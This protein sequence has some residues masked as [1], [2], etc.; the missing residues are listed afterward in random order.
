L[1]VAGC[2][3]P[4][5]DPGSPPPM[6]PSRSPGEYAPFRASGTAVIE[7]RVAGSDADSVVAGRVVVLDPNTPYAQRWYAEVG[8][9][10][11]RFDELPADTGFKSLR[12]ST[13][14]DSAGKFRFA[15][16]APGTYIIAI[17]IS[18]QTPTGRYQ[19]GA[20]TG[21]LTHVVAVAAAETARV[22]TLRR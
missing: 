18:W 6:P 5:L 11:G 21:V 14:T 7:G 8:L 17:P 22:P 10:P 2:A 4:Q 12:R 20:Q 1:L 9:I 15:G 13:T 19:L 3:V 16:L